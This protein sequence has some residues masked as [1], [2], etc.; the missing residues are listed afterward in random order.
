[1]S[2]E[3]TKGKKKWYLRWWMF[4]VYVI[5]AIIILSSL[6]SSDKTGSGTQVENTPAKQE[7]KVEAIKITATKLVQAYIDNEVNADTLY[8]GKDVEISGSIKDIGKDILDT[9]Y[10][11]IESNPSDYFT[12]VQCMFNKEDVTLLGS[13]KKGASIVV[14]GKLS[15]KLGNVLVRE[16]KIIQ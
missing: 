7:I 1:M 11:T 5:V 10:I 14:Q 12:Q 15:S 8:K 6:G 4:I 16:C 13:L 3:V 2:E 9:P